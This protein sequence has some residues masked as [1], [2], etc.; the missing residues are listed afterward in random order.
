MA[1]TAIDLGAQ[2][3]QAIELSEVTRWL[4][5]G[6]SANII[7]DRLTY[8][9]LT[10]RP[11]RGAE[12]NLRQAGATDVVVLYV[13]QMIV[14]PDA[15]GRDRPTATTAPTLRRNVR[16]DDDDALPG[17]VT[18]ARAAFIDGDAGIGLTSI[19]AWYNPQ[20][21]RPR[22]A[23]LAS[24]LAGV[25]PTL[26]V[27]MWP[28]LSTAGGVGFA[29]AVARNLFVGDGY[30]GANATLWRLEATGLKRIGAGFLTGTAGVH[31]R[32]GVRTRTDGVDTLR[33][34]VG[35]TATRATL[36]WHVP[37]R[38]DPLL[39][40]TISL[41]AELAGS[42]DGQPGGAHGGVRI[43][44]ADG[45]VFAA[46]EYVGGYRAAG[47]PT[48]PFNASRTVSAR[49]DGGGNGMLAIG[50]RKTWRWR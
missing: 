23:S 19:H 50:L 3:L 41:I 28:V 46:A 24:A 32:R 38:G 39:G 5:S 15:G 14:C 42:G 47:T 18:S 9:C 16:D 49:D 13:R 33:A 12:A 48:T 45:P 26:D 31:G 29:G 2:S 21:A 20:S 40:V 25:G 44:W 8:R 36:G 1:C 11:P 43:R 22:I 35:F 30:G 7:V 34:R 17:L 37:R 4:R 6:E 27:R 10:Q